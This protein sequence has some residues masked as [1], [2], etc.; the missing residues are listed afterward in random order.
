MSRQAR[1]IAL[2]MFQLRLAEHPGLVMVMQVPVSQRAADR[3]P[4]LL[5]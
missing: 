4:A 2:E 5:A 3:V 1:T